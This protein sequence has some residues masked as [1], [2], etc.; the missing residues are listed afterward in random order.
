MYH[1]VGSVMDYPGAQLC[2]VS[3]L[4]SLEISRRRFPDDAITFMLGC[5][6]TGPVEIKDAMTPWKMRQHLTYF[7]IS[8]V[9][10]QS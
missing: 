1:F 7:V 8:L 10:N 6:N 9:Q 4:I 2:V 3:N 5:H